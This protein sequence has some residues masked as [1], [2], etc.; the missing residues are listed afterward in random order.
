MTY[1][2]RLWEAYEAYVGCVHGSVEAAEAL[3]RLREAILDTSD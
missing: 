2:E 3:D 1:S